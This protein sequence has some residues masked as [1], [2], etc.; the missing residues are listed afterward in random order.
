VQATLEAHDT[1]DRG[2]FVAAAG[3]GVLCTVQLVPFQRS[4]NLT[5]T[6]ELSK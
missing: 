6:P 3:L 4:A 1:P 5:L 2:L